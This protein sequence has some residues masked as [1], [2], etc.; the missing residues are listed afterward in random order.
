MVGMTKAVENFDALIRENPAYSE[1]EYLDAIRGLS[2]K[3]LLEKQNEYLSGLEKI[4]AIGFQS[5]VR[6]YLD[7]HPEKADEIFRRLNKIIG[8]NP[9]P[10]TKRLSDDELWEG[11]KKWQEEDKE[12]AE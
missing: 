2:G 8:H 9:K 11:I 4:S 1:Q 6:T 5:D 10:E 7:R 12:M 3:A